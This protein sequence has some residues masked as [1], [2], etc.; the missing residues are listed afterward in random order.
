MN[1]VE[2]RASANALFKSKNFEEAVDVYGEALE[3]AESAG[4]PVDFRLK[5]LSQRS[6]VLLRLQRFEEAFG[7]AKRCLQL[8]PSDPKAQQ[9]VVAV[10]AAATAKG[11]P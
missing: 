7:D 8:S 11:R 4:D 3:A 10:M 6:T 2:L 9:R 5:I 1:A